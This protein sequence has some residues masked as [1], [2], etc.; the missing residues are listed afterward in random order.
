M[1]THEIRRAHDD[2]V[3]SGH[4]CNACAVTAFEQLTLAQMMGENPLGPLE[5]VE[6]RLI[7]LA[8]N[9]VTASAGGLVPLDGVAP[10][11]ILS[12]P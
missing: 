2:S 8:T 6:A 5:P 3:I 9:E 12:W 11:E 10:A 1:V 7:D 4:C